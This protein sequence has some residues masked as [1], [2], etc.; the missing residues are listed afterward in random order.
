MSSALTVD[1]ERRQIGEAVTYFIRL[2]DF[3]NDFEQQLAFYNDSRAA[4]TNLDAVYVTLVQLVNNLAMETYRIIKGK[5]SRKTGDFV[6]SCIAYNF[7]TIPSITEVRSKLDLYL[8][9]GQIAL[10]NNCL[11]QADACFEVALKSVAELPKQIEV[12]GK[13]KSMEPYLVSYLKNFLSML[14][15]APDSPE[16]GALYLFR[17]LVEQ[18]QAYSF[19]TGTLIEVYLSVLDTLSIMSQETY[20]FHL[21]NGK[22]FLYFFFKR[23]SYKD[24]FVS[25]ISN[26]EL[27]G[28]DEKYLNE[29]N[30]I[31]TQITSQI[32]LSLKAL[33]DAGNFRM[34]ANLALQLFHKI[35]LYSDILDDK[36]YQLAVNLWNLAIKQRTNVR[37]ADFV[38]YLTSIEEEIELADDNHR[39]ARLIE[40]YNR[41]KAKL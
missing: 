2:V 37:H 25:V 18:V 35:V 36:T 12:D 17:L 6:K 10:L 23:M 28:Q 31:C 9:T 5:H 24:P 38:G 7:V 11:G 34:Q 29:I 39:K 26:D 41:V 8:L 32:L 33:A 22:S 27:Y 19:E 4:F 16:M 20:P 40:L 13:P 14:I 1:D 21:E 15:I 30:K 3:G